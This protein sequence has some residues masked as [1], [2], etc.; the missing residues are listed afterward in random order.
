MA[1]GTERVDGLLILEVRAKRGEQVAAVRGL[2]TK[3]VVG[4]TDGASPL[5]ARRIAIDGRNKAPFEFRVPVPA[6]EYGKLTLGLAELV[7]TTVED[8]EEKV[9]LA[10]GETTFPVT[11]NLSPEAPTRVILYLN[12]DGLRGAKTPGDVLAVAL[13]DAIPE[14]AFEA[15]KGEAATFRLG[16]AAVGLGARSLPGGTRV[17]LRAPNPDDLPALFRRQIRVGEPLEV[18]AA[19]KLAAPAE[20]TIPYDPARLAAAGVQPENAVV[21]QLDDARTVYRELKPIRFDP[22]AGTLTV[23]VRSFSI[24]FA[25]TPGIEIRSPELLA[26]GF[27]R[28]LGFVEGETATIAGRATD[29]AAQVALLHPAVPSTWAHGGHFNFENVPLAAAEI[30]VTLEARVEG[31][32]PHVR[33]FLLRKAIVPRRITDPR[34]AFGAGLAM[35]ASDAPRVSTVVAFDRFTS[36]GLIPPLADWQRSYNRLGPFLYR[37]NDAR[38]SWTFQPLLPESHFENQAAA[39]A[40]RLLA[41]TIQVPILLAA[42]EETRALASLAAFAAGLGA[43]DLRRPSIDRALDLARPLFGANTLSVSPRVPLVSLGGESLGA[44]FVAATLLATDDAL[45]SALGFTFRNLYGALRDRE[46]DRPQPRAGRLFWST[47]TFDAMEREVVA[48]GIWCAAVAPVLD[49]QT[50]QPVIAAIGVAPDVLWVRDDGVHVEEPRSRLLIYRRQAEGGWTEEVVLDDRAVVDVDLAIGEDGIPRLVAAVAA[51]RDL[52]AKTHVVTVRFEAGSWHVAPLAIEVE[53]GGRTIRTDRGIWPR[54]AIDGR[55]R[56]VIV[57]AQWGAEWRWHLAVEEAGGFR[58]RHLRTALWV[59][60]AG[61]LLAPEGDRRL[62]ENLPV[63]ASGLSVAHWAASIALE[64]PSILWCAYPNGMLQLARIDLDTLEIEDSPIAVDRSIGFFPALALRRDG[65]PAI[66]FKDPLGQDRGDGDL[67][68]LS[69]D[70]GAVVPGLPLHQGTGSRFGPLLPPYEVGVFSIRGFAPHVPLDCATLK[71]VNLFPRLLASIV[72][73]RRFHIEI[74]P[75]GGLGIPSS[76]AFTRSHPQLLLRLRNFATLPTVLVVIIDNRDFPSEGIERVVITAFPEPVLRVP[77]AEGL[78]LDDGTVPASLVAAL[79]TQGLTLH[80]GFLTSTVK[81]RENSW[82]IVD[83]R[84]S[85]GGLRTFSQLYMLRRGVDPET[86]DDVIEIHLPAVLSVV[87]RGEV[88]LDDVGRPVPCDTEQEDWDLLAGPL[89]QRFAKS[90]IKIPRG[91]PGRIVFIAMR[92]L[93]VTRMEPWDPQGTEQ[94][95][96]VRFSMEIPTLVGRNEEPGGNLYSVEPTNLSVTL[97][98]SVVQGRIVWWIR[99]TELRVGRVEADVDLGPFDFLR[100]VAGLIPGFGLLLLLADPIVDT[101]ASSAVNDSLEPPDTASFQGLFREALQGWTDATLGKAFPPVESVYLRDGNLRFWSRT[102]RAEGQRSAALEILPPEDLSFPSARLGEE[103]AR[104]HLLLTSVGGVPSLV[105]SV[106]LLSG[107]PEMRIDGPAPGPIVLVPGATLTVPLVFEP[108]APPGFRSGQIEVIAN[109]GTRTLVNLHGSVAAPLVPRLR[110]RPSNR[111]SFSLVT[112]GTRREEPVEII[113]DGLAWLIVTPPRIEGDSA[114][115]PVFSLA[116]PPLAIAPGTSSALRIAYAPPVGSPS[117]HD[118]LLVLESNDPAQP[119]VELPVVG[120]AAGLGSLYVE[121]LSLAFHDTVIE[122]NQP[123]LPPGLP[124]TIH[125][126]ATLRARIFN[127][128]TGPITIQAATFRIPQPNGSPSPHFRLWLLDGSAPAPNDRVLLGG[129]ELTLVVQFLPTTV[130]PH[131]ATLTIR[132]SDAVQPV[133]P[134]ALAG[135]G[136]A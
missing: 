98:P 43:T 109:G 77:A 6:G 129:E 132:T 30:S 87:A 40:I 106:R 84:A 113:N 41:P 1:E 115:P 14:Q 59:D 32:L 117:R 88:A 82:E 3:L 10:K 71:D 54:I 48:D 52:T 25:G 13:D 92:D 108:Q 112:V 42:P 99:E 133:I 73:D 74:Y 53:V 104:R 62:Q 93:R 61:S 21:L 69:T 65:A 103:P 122:A 36:E 128:G 60:L 118:A 126:G 5:F 2:L 28:V 68:F 94:Q 24:F 12:L 91:T 47:G 66:V 134:V 100:V 102:A 31:E 38:D 72:N 105:Q 7:L 136:V 50:G 56:S 130:G 90:P 35:T 37:P 110:L 101:I 97:A 70:D 58:A 17:V 57:F 49:P 107:E 85:A 64:G 34:R 111:L 131:Q 27:G 124:P 123:Q 114:V 121:S 29:P 127:L 67:F 8:K 4:A 39:L 23:R 116:A 15:P 45:D 86:Q 55:G 81:E 19:T 78:G 125:L 79:A 44:A 95:G 119:R 75:D 26:D 46:A 9:T 63:S 20:V 16:L 135:V 96:G 80:P 33:E 51:T 22:R 76:L 89:I 18:R 11:L 83:A 120:F